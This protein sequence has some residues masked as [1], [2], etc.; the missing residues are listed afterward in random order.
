MCPKNDL[1]E[2]ETGKDGP[3]GGRQKEAIRNRCRLAGTGGVREDDLS[4]SAAAAAGS[5]RD[6]GKTEESRISR[7][8]NSE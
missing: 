4:P 6:H 3:E 8:T 1:K 2:R 7:G 5:S